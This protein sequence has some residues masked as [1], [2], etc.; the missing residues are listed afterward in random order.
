VDYGEV[1]SYL[2]MHGYAT[3]DQV[4]EAREW[5]RT[6]GGDFFQ[7]LIGRGVNS[8]DAYETKAV[9]MQVPFVDLTVYK[10]DTSAINSV[11]AYIANRHNIIPIKKDGTTLYVAMSNV[12]DV[13]VNDDIRL[14]SRCYVR[15]VLAVPEEISLAIQR[16]YAVQ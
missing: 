8:R 1:E 7:I 4:R 11:P 16:Y 9:V 5:Q 14:A 10:P 3:P 15:G 2:V 12:N 13:T 6:T